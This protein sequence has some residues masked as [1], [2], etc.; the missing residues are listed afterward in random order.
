MIRN[1]YTSLCL[2]M[3]IV[4]LSYFDL[5]A[6]TEIPL[7]FI[8][9][10]GQVTDQFGNAR[11][12]VHFQLKAGN[13]L[14]IFIASGAIYYQFCKADSAANT[15]VQRTI[16]GH[17]GK[18]SEVPAPGSYSM[19]RMDVELIGA[20]RS[21]KIITEQ[22]QD[23]HENYFTATTGK[24]GATALSYDRITYKDI[25]PNIDWVLYTTGGKLKHEFWVHEGGNVK[26][27]RLRYGGA[28]GLKIDSEGNLIASTPQGSVTEAAPISFQKDGKK[29]PSRFVLD[30]TQLSFET[31]E[32]TGDLIIDPS[33]YWAT[34]YGGSLQEYPNG[35][36]TDGSGNVYITGH[37][38][39]MAAI[40]TI[41][42]HQLYFAGGGHDVYLAKF[43]SSGAI[44]WATYYGGS[45]QDYGYGVATDGSGNVYITGFTFSAYGIATSGAFDTAISGGDAFLVKFNAAGARQWATYFGGSMLEECRGVAT[46]A[47]GDVYITGK[48]ESSSG[49]A[50]PGAHQTV[51]AGGTVYACDGFLA[52][53]SSAG[54]RLWATYY[55]G[56]DDDYGHDVATD[57]SGNVYITGYTISVSG[58]ATPGSYQATFGGGPDDA[59]LAKFSSTGSILW[60]TYYGG[61]QNDQGHSLAIDGSGY[62]Y[63]AGHTAS[64]S[65]IVS[66]GAHQTSF[67]SGVYDGFF[68]R[69]SSAGVRQWAT[70]YGGSGLDYV[71]GIAADVSG[72][73]FIAGYTQSYTGI[74]TPGTYLVAHSGGL[75]DGYLAKFNNAGIRQ[76]GSYFGGSSYDYASDVCTDAGT[77]VYIAGYTES[78]WAIAT[79]GSYQ[80]AYGG[81]TDAF[82]AKFDG[83]FIPPVVG[84][85]TGTAT[86]CVG[87]NTTL[88]NTTTG[89]TWMSSS[90]GVAAVGYFSGVVT[91][92]APGTATIAYNTTA[93]T[94]TIVVTVYAVPGPITAPLFDVCVGSNITL[95]NATS[96]GTWSSSATGTAT[97]GA[98]SGIVTG[99]AAGTA[100]ITY[101]RSGCY[102]TQEVTVLPLPDPAISGT[103][104]VCAGYTVVLAG[105]TPGGTW[106]SSDPGVGAVDAI[107]G[108]VYGISPGATTIKYLVSNSCGTDSATQTVTVVAASL[109]TTGI[110]PA[111]GA[112][113]I[114][115]MYPNPSRGT[116]TI[117]SASSIEEKVDLIVVN[118]VGERVREFTIYTDHATEIELDQPPGIYFIKIVNGSPG[119]VAKLI[120]Q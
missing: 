27:L 16:P 54:A 102:V 79:S 48:T 109:C 78:G 55:G 4:L 97:V 62:V 91:G 30:G 92:I 53:F 104:T 83:S 114:L 34:Y 23:Y 45:D 87:S 56:T 8:K 85:I 58:I 21:A 99:V 108:M 76:W 6:K 2:L 19:Y 57:A 70:Y 80:P 42:A 46:D 40:A 110:L 74:S 69:F 61:S 77:G 67:A 31:G 44:Q 32:Y 63:M 50:T 9:N 25:Y 35:T 73:V 115:H 1:K 41:G 12:D 49:I 20:N 28:T 113:T 64:S 89:G 43:N 88:S 52:K 24:K 84:P 96:G 26:D 71:Y 100:S 98:G 29:V 17:T 106:S 101:N 105:A 5:S 66:P 15:Q 120:I 37:T 38:E 68:T 111:N 22:R 118:M 47:S 39:S 10:V 18:G 103:Y 7:A 90:T 11:D 13:G 116:F 75:W 86:V 107:T 33:L 119:Y 112:T 36:A 94:A 65:G 117:R 51:F 14:N 3:G 59:F 72:N 81:S 60:A 95:A 93:G 82:L